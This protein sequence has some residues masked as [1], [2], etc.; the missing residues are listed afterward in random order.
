MLRDYRNFDKNISVRRA[1]FVRRYFEWL[2][3]C[4]LGHCFFVFGH[5]DRVC[6]CFSD[7]SEFNSIDLFLGCSV[8]IHLRSKAARPTEHDGLAH[9]VRVRAHSSHWSTQFKHVEPGLALARC[10]FWRFHKIIIDITHFY[11]LCFPTSHTLR[12]RCRCHSPA[13]LHT[14]LT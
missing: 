1:H 4:T 3:N 10:F 12:H 9:L 2:F 13:L 14:C 11:I 7:S 5:D 8:R 6:A